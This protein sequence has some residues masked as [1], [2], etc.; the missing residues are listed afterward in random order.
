[1]TKYTLHESIATDRFGTLVVGSSFDSKLDELDEPEVNREDAEYWTRETCGW[2]ENSY[3]V[4]VA[5]DLVGLIEQ[6]PGME[7]V[8]VF[9]TWNRRA[10]GSDPVEQ[11]FARWIEAM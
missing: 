5:D 4:E 11:V 8:S 1:M 2:T 9:R 7:C 3:D 10:Q 6:H